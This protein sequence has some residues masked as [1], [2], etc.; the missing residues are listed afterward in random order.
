M[1]S[2]THAQST[3]DPRELGKINSQIPHTPSQMTNTCSLNHLL[4]KILFTVDKDD[5]WGS[6]LV[7]GNETSSVCS[8]NVLKEGE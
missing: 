6:K 4:A 2:S 1:E 7:S 8:L 3:T 5:K